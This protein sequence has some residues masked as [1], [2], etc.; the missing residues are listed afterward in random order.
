MLA[1]VACGRDT[2]SPPQARVPGKP[3]EVPVGPIHSEQVNTID[4]RLAGCRQDDSKL[5]YVVDNEGRLSSFDPRKLP[6]D[7]FRPVGAIACGPEMKPEAMAVDRD[8]IA[9]IVTKKGA[10]YNASIRDAS[11]RQ[12]GQLESVHDEEQIGLAFV[13]D[14]AGVDAEKLY[15]Q[16][17]ERR[18]EVFE[19]TPELRL[20]RRGTLDKGDPALTGTSDAKLYAFFATLAQ[21]YVQELDPATGAGVGKRWL[22]PK[23]KQ[24][25]GGWAI[26][27]WAGTFY[28]FVTEVQQNGEASSQLATLDRAT[29]EY[30]TIITHLPH[31]IADAG[32]S[33]CVL[34]SAA[35]IP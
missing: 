29:G 32:A 28:L 7:A 30:R 15:A 13:A 3:P 22:I 24:R 21:P 2:E 31:L 4:A 17:G 23:P 14:A 12:I 19:T 16:I 35:P 8:G 5:I 1:V 10:L 6:G 11:C 26:A 18:L 25:V 34:G 9:W 33:T 27:Q 20:V